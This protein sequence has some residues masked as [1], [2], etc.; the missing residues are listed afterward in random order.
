MFLIIVIS[1]IIQG[2]TVHPSQTWNIGT[3]VSSVAISPDGQSVAVGLEDG[4]IQ[5]RKAVDG[6]LIWSVFAHPAQPGYVGTTAV[7][8]LAFSHDGS[9]LAS[10]GVD[11]LMFLWQTSNGA[12]LRGWSNEGQGV[13]ALAFSPDDALLATSGP[14]GSIRI[15][16]LRTGGVAN[17]LPGNNF[18]YSLGYSP[19]GRDLTSVSDGNM[20]SQWQ[21]LTGTLLESQQIKRFGGKQMI[22]SSAVDPTGHFAAL[23]L[24]SE[25]QVFVATLGATSASKTSNNEQSYH[26]L[27]GHNAG[28]W[29]LAFSPSGQLLASGGGRLNISG[30]SNS[31]DT[32]I[33]VWDIAGMKQIALLRGHTGNVTGVAWG[34]DNNQLVSGSQDG[35][36]ILWKVK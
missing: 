3:P 19:S 21:L 8:K 28:I 31:E 36:V 27:K 16:N 5:L 35:T 1:A 20:I 18:V 10:A 33:R 15:L 29:S 14:G 34:P 25:N 32:P 2:P 11:N 12:Q 30:S 6:K 13:R 7:S 26:A 24:D 23:A 4:H 9:M 22:T 17:T